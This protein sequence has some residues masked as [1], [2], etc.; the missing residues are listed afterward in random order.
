MTTSE[1]N[2]GDGGT[3]SSRARSPVGGESAAPLG[4]Q[5]LGPTSPFS[6][7]RRASRRFGNLNAT[8]TAS[9]TSVSEEA[10]SGVSI[11]SVGDRQ[12][13]DVVTSPLELPD[14]MESRILVNRYFDFA[15]ATY[16][17]LHQPTTMNWLLQLNEDVTKGLDTLPSIQKAILLLVFATGIL[18]NVDD[19][20][21]VLPE[22]SVGPEGLRLIGERYYQA[23]QLIISRETGPLQ[24]ESIQARLASTLYLLNT[25]RLNQAWYMFGTTYQL[26]IA[27]GLHRKGSGHGLQ[28][29]Y[30]LSECRKR[31]FWTTYTLDGYFSVMLGRPPFLHDEFVDQAFPEPLNDQDITPNVISRKSKGIDCLITASIVH[32]KLARVVRRASKDQ[33]LL[34]QVSEERQIQTAA[35]LNGEIAK[36]QEDLPIFLS[37]AINPA[38]LIPVFRR[39]V[40]VLRM[41]CAHAVMLVNRPLILSRTARPKDVQ[42]HVEECLSAAKQMLDLVLDFVADNHMFQGFWKTQYVTFNAL[43]IVYVWIIQRKIGRLANVASQYEEAELFNIAE[44]AQTPLAKATQSNAPNLRYTIILGE[45]QREA[46]RV[47]GPDSSANGNPNTSSSSGQQASSNP[48]MVSPRTE[49]APASLGSAEWDLGSMDFPLDPNLWMQLDSFPFTNSHFQDNYGFP[50]SP[51]LNG[52][53]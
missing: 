4:Q 52:Q 47:I 10:K 3:Q 33:Y 17:F 2:D 48:D 7:I 43:S 31:S 49:E 53:L 19:S 1:A 42:P 26:V 24:L 45:L 30:V 51:N 50:T 41:A 28:K 32:A 34:H 21:T 6:F 22:G 40:T 38:S 23:A 39:Q 37:G 29:D 16:R 25:S 5:Y 20:H 15:M 14:E 36:W 12:F 35:Q 44:A 27:L 9:T 13:P 11:F 18:Y 46:R 8:S